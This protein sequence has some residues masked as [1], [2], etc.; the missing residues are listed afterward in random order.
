MKQ[1]LFS[2]AVIAL[3]LA[4]ATLSSATVANPNDLYG[5]AAPT[6]AAERTIVIDHD[7]NYVN[8]TSGDVV[9][10]V[11]HGKEYAWS[12]DTGGNIAVMDLNQ[13]LP[14]GTLH[15]TV[16]VYLARDPTYTGA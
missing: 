3:A 14:P 8:L 9:K 7:T 11:V 4:G 1:K 2:L 5:E 10:F 12:F 13:I 6:A 15:H 16:K